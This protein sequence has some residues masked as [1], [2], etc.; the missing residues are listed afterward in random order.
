M[1][2]VELSIARP[3]TRPPMPTDPT[4]AALSRVYEAESARVHGMVLLRCGDRSVAEDVTAR[5][6]EA[7]ARAFADGRGHEVTP[8]WLTTVAKR[9][10]VDHWRKA[11][12][13]ER[14]GEALQSAAKTS[15]PTPVADTPEVW[16]ALDALPP[17]QRAAVTLRYLEEWSVSEIAD[18]L[19]LSYKAAESLLARGRTSLRA[20]L[21]HLREP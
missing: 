5:T 19:D 15:A 6:F 1:G 2:S 17:S 12:R 16:E 11:G 21:T 7:A 3:P 8:A 20:A 10:L 9:R 13:R 4:L 14:L 18:G